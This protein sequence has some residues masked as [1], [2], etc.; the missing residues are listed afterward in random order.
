MRGGKGAGGKDLFPGKGGAKNQTPKKDY[1]GERLKKDVTAKERPPER[2]IGA[3]RGRATR[4]HCQR[5][6]RGRVPR[7]ETPTVVGER[8]DTDTHHILEVKTVSEDRK[9]VSNHLT[10]HY[11]GA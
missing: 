7:E 4:V 3:Q 10:L 9:P 5:G 1:A 2:A 8:A 11:F 6:G